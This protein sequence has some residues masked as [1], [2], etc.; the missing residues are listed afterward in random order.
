MA[1]FTSASA[2]NAAEITATAKQ[3]TQ[4]YFKWRS[5]GGTFSILG[6][7]QYQ[8]SPFCHGV[9]LNPS[10]TLVKLLPF[11]AH[12]SWYNTYGV[13]GEGDLNP[14]PPPCCPVP[15]SYKFNFDPTVIVAPPADK[16]VI[17]NNATP[18]SATKIFIDNDTIFNLDISVLLLGIQY[19]AFFL[20]HCENYWLYFYVTNH[21]DQTTYVEYDVTF[22]AEYGTT[23]TSICEAEIF[24]YY[25]NGNE[26]AGA[27]S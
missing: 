1:K 11:D 16:T 8:I 24:F 10:S 5:F 23:P 27:G 25:F 2:D 6:T 9:E 12:Q 14:S 15:I 3:I 26:P 17:I 7:E 21:T 18:S 22:L 19:N 13:E 20:I 4:D